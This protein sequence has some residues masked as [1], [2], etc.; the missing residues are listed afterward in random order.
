MKNTLTLLLLAAM[1]VTATAQQITTNYTATNYVAASSYGTALLTGASN[2]MRFYR[3]VTWVMQF[4]GEGTDSSG[5]I[6][7]YFGD[8]YDRYNTEFLTQTNYALVATAN[9]TNRVTATLTLTNYP[10]TFQTPARYSNT[11]ANALTNFQLWSISKHYLKD[12]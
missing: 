2:D 3:T 1:A 11:V 10:F 4:Q 6:S 12:Q 8:G 9:G 7:V 5:V